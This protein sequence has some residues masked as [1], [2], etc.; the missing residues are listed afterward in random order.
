MSVSYKFETT[1]K[2]SETWGNHSQ[3][4]ILRYVDALINL[5]VI[6]LGIWPWSHREQQIRLGGCQ[7]S[8]LLFY[9]FLSYFLCLLYMFY[10]YL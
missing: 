8:L 4:F 3:G 1:E 9:F 5:L 2:T 10:I 7:V 6:S